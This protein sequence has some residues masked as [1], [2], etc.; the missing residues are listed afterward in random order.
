MS[1]PLLAIVALIPILVALVLMVWFRMG[2]MK[3][4]PLAWL[5]C[6]AGAVLVWD[7]PVN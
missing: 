5:A 3:A 7:L 1:I 6:A 4:M 2:A